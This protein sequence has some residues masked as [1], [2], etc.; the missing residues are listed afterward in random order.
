[1]DIRNLIDN[2]ITNYLILERY[3]NDGSPSG[4]SIVTTKNDTAPKCEIKEFKLKLITIKNLIESFIFG[5]DIINIPAN[6]IFVHPDMLEHEIFKKIDY[7]VLD[8]I[9]V[10]PSTWGE[11]PTISEI[12][13]YHY[14]SLKTDV[15]KLFKD[16]L[17]LELNEGVTQEIIDELTGKSLL[18]LGFAYTLC[19]L[20]VANDYHKFGGFESKSALFAIVPIVLGLAAASLHVLTLNVQKEEKQEYV[21]KN[22]LDLYKQWEENN[23]TAQKIYD[24]AHADLL[25]TMFAYNLDNLGF[26]EVE[27][28]L[29]STEDLVSSE[30]LNELEV[31]ELKTLNKIRFYVFYCK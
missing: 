23:L 11:M 3:I 28:D 20:L 19:G 24:F 4:F 18:I 17:M 31:N 26:E 7:E 9:I 14:D 22:R 25:E 12:K 6:A 13:I 21:V 8:E 1:M 30:A 5:E 10:A 15:A 27:E 29:E 2:Y 16:N